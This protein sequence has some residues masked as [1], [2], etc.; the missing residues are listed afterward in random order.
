MV[1]VVYGNGQ[2]VEDLARDARLSEVFKGRTLFRYSYELARSAFIPGQL[3]EQSLRE[4]KREKFA[5]EINEAFE[6]MGE[7]NYLA[8]E[9]Q[10]VPGGFM[11]VYE[12]IRPKG[13]QR[14][15]PLPRYSWK[16]HDQYRMSQLIGNTEHLR[17]RGN[18]FPDNI[19]TAAGY[20]A[21]I[22]LAYGISENPGHIK[23]Y[24]GMG[25][26][27]LGILVGLPGY[28][29]LRNRSLLT[30]T[31]DLNM[32]RKPWHQLQ[33]LDALVQARKEGEEALRTFDKGTVS[34]PADAPRAQK[35]CLENN[36]FFKSLGIQVNPNYQ[37]E[38]EMR[39]ARLGL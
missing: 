8:C 31:K 38:R 21:V 28:A 7:T 4:E 22:G 26:A 12:T 30:S 34:L 18:F 23:E 14:I 1:E 39:L 13:L 2:S 17:W 27:A 10:G 19:I 37:S 24:M 15:M 9:A 20:G 5:L 29:V 25:A 32:P 35:R 11:E 16:N 36:P 6:W 3:Q 33:F